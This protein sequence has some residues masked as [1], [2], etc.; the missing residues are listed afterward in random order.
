MAALMLGMIT[1]YHL[2]D[3]M[4]GPMSNPYYLALGITKPTIALVRATIG[5]GG[6]LAGIA[7]GG[8]CSLWLGNYRTLILGAVLQPLGIGAFAL[9]GWHGGDYALVSLGA[10]RL[11]AFEAIMAFDALAIGFSGVAL[12]SYMSTL[13]SLGYT[14]TQYALLTSALT[15]MGKTLKGFSGTLVEGLQHSRSLLSAYAEFYV[16]SAAI[17]LPAILLCL[18]LATRPTARLTRS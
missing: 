18:M 17:G 7:L 15:W 5:L 3:Y 14:A 10:A 6:S 16:I 13:T 9:L 2:C 8:L 1:F 12:V 4:R 11:T